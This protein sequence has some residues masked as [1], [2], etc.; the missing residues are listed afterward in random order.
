MLASKIISS[1]PTKDLLRSSS[2]EKIQSL[3]GKMLLELAKK[4]N[5]FSVLKKDKYFIIFCM[6]TRY[7]RGREIKTSKEAMRRV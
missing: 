5:I 6:L 3:F 4:K 7:L 1:P 2:T